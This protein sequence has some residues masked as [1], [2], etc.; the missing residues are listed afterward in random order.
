VNDDF[1]TTLGLKLLAGRTFDRAQRTDERNTGTEEMNVVIDRV[2]AEQLGFAQP[3]E[4]VGKTFYRPGSGNSAARPLRIIGVVAARTLTPAGATSSLYVLDPQQALI[5]SVR[6]AKEDIPAAL[7]EIDSVWAK[8]APNVPMKR[9]FAD[10]VW[11][12]FYDYVRVVTSAF[13]ALAALAFVNAGLGLLGISIHAI[14][15]RTREIGVRKA[16]GASV[17]RILTLLLKS[18]SQPVIIGNLIACPLA[19]LAMRLYLTLFTYRV[20]LSLFPFVLSLLITVVIA[21]VTVGGHALG[22]ARARPS[23]VL[24][25][26]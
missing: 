25:Y 24:R 15:R 19:L 7:A 1:F 9:Q 14:G 17:S 16:L 4:A 5:P 10:Q 23:R 20:N 2:L 18:A 8:I 13:A 6:I 12:S 11:D 21:W 3:Q 22:A 26:E